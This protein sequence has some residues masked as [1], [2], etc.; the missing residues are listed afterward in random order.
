M[1]RP[2]PIFVDTSVISSNIFN[3][4]DDE[5]Y[6]FIGQLTGLEEAG[7]L[8]VQGIRT[9]NSFLRIENVFDVLTID[10]EEIN[11]IKKDICFMLNDNTYIIKSGIKVSFEYLRDLFPRK[12]KEMCKNINHDNSNI[13]DT[14]SP[15]IPTPEITPNE[16]TTM[17][18][19]TTTTTTTTASINVVDHRSSIIQ[20]I[21]EWCL[22]HGN[23][24]NIPGLK[25]IDGCDYFLSLPSYGSDFVHIRCACR[26][27][28]K[29]LRQGSHFQLSNYYRH[30]KTKK[31]FYA[32]VEITNNSC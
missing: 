15:M 4:H 20:A 17:K 7:F 12:Q 22:R 6:S 5:F 25:L 27:S 28:A 18:T 16:S 24:L 29:L 30:L 19:T 11:N 13:S 1:S 21:D 10:A 32:Q 8:K 23:E 3:Y 31:M 2:K 26:A 9:V 14:P